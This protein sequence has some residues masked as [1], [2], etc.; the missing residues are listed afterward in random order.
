M[1]RSSLA[2]QHRRPPVETIDYQK[3]TVTLKGPEGNL[4]TSRVAKSVKR[5]VVAALSCSP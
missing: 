5:F 1:A 4:A 2:W 3:R